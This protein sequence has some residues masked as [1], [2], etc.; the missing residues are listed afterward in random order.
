[1][2]TYTASN[3]IEEISTLD[4]ISAPTAAVS[5]LAV[6]SSTKFNVVV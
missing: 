1:M 4:I 5:G 3:P 2:V 6:S